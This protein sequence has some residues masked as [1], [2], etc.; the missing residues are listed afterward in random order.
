[1]DWEQIEN[2]WAAMTSRVR[3]DWVTDTADVKSLPVHRGARPDV[4]PTIL[5]DRP[6]GQVGDPR[7][8]MSIE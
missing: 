7:V 8:K 1:M 3:A 6:T 2:K 5:A 4:T